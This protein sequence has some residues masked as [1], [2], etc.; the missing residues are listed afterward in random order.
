MSP[1]GSVTAAKG[2]A[3]TVNSVEMRKMSRNVRFMR[4]LEMENF[5]DDLM[6]DSRTNAR[7]VQPLNLFRSYQRT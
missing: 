4:K 7:Q 3:R 5:I 1:H 2:A 6:K